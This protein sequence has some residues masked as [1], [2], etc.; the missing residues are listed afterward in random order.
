MITMTMIDY[1]A[2]CG[3]YDDGCCSC[4]AANCMEIFFLILMITITMIDDND[5]CG[6]YDDGCCSCVGAN[7][8]EIFFSSR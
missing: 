2:N 7:C 8:M 5:N 3:D 4:V 6:D 1:N